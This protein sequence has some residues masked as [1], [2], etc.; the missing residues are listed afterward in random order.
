VPEPAGFGRSA[1]PSHPPRT[2]NHADLGDDLLD[3]LFRKEIVVLNRYF[4]RPTTVDRIRASWIGEAIERY[5]VWLTEQHYA[6]RNVSFRVPVLVRFGE[7]AR[8]SGA[9]KVD[10]LPAHIEPCIEDWL[11]RRKQGYSESQRS[12]AARELRNPIRQLL[13][14]ALPDQA[15][16]A[17]NAPDPFADVAPG[18]F[19]FLR[20]DRGLRETTIVQYRYYLQRLQDYLQRLDRPLLSKGS[21]DHYFPISRLPLSV[22]S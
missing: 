22:V 3:C 19:G 13:H 1:T 7:F 2:H 17:K 8:T 11:D 10:D 5:V 21:I 14:L 4:I 20:R 6:A 16:D 15:R 12:V 9:S 18:F